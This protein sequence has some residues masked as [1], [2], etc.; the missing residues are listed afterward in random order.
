LGKSTP[1]EIL[2]I[3]SPQ[4]LSNLDEAQSVLRAWMQSGNRTYHRIDSGRYLIFY[5]LQDKT[6]YYQDKG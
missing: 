6:Y 5:N 4:A 2:R 1:V 3:N